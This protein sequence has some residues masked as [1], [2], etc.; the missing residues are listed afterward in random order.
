MLPTSFRNVEAVN[1]FIDQSLA[2][3]SDKVLGH[4]CTIW[5]PFKAGQVAKLPQLK[6]ASKRIKK[7][8]G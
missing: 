1:R 7:A 8:R 5:N 6:A 4:L 2:V 3:P